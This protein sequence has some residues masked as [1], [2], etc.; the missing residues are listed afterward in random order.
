M[1]NVDADKAQKILMYLHKDQ[2][3]GMDDLNFEPPQGY[4]RVDICAYSGKKAGTHCRRTFGEY[5]KPSEIPLPDDACSMAAVDKRNGLLATPWTPEEM[6]EY[7]VFVDLDPWYREWQVSARLS[8]RPVMLSL[9]DMPSKLARQSNKFPASQYDLSGTKPVAITIQ[10]PENGACIINNPETPPAMNSIA[11]RAV[12]DPFISQ[13]LWYVDG[14]PFKLA[15]LPSPVRWPLKKG[16]HRF[17]VRL[18][19]RNEVS[20]IVKITVE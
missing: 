4:E 6:K 12:T 10:S 13:V 17:Q 14:K 7:R 18:P 8:T 20:D 15:T 1:A 9:L 3:L 5:F 2:A 19:F 11:L 16:L